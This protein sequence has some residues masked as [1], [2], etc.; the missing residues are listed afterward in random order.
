MKTIK[1]IFDNNDF[2][3]LITR[4]NGTYEQIENYYLN[5]WFNCGTFNDDMKQCTKI[6]YLE[7]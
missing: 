5:K 2:D 1:V 3:Y 7:C 6:E 4:I